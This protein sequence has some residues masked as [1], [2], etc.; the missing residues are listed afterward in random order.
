MKEFHTHK[1]KKKEPGQFKKSRKRNLNIQHNR[2]QL[3]LLKEG[4]IPQAELF[5][6]DPEAFKKVTIVPM[7][8]D[9]PSLGIDERYGVKA[10]FLFKHGKKSRLRTGWIVEKDGFKI[11]EEPGGHINYDNCFGIV[12][13]EE[14]LKEKE[15]K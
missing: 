15:I 3:K 13:K 14:I 5:I 11:Y 7:D 8:A 10:A 9:L 12:I 6:L 1:E 4:K 2:D